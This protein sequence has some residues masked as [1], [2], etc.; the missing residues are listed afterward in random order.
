MGESGVDIQLSN[1]AQKVLPYAI[2]CKRKKVFA[3]YSMYE[4]AEANKG[5]LEPLLVIRGDRK[6]PLA[7]VD[8]DHFLELAKNGK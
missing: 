5:S 3:I 8:L 2:E 1:R 7:V 6:K 4:Q